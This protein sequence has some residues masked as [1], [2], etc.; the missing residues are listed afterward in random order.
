[1]IAA[2]ALGTSNFL[3]TGSAESSF[4][5]RPAH[6]LH[7]RPMIVSAEGQTDDRANCRRLPPAGQPLVFEIGNDLP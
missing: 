3:S 2:S 7:H 6:L 4:F 1:M 5:G